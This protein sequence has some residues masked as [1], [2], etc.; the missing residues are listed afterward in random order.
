MKFR[1][2]HESKSRCVEV[3]MQVPPTSTYRSSTV[4]YK[5]H[6]SGTISMIKSVSLYKKNGLLNCQIRHI[7]QCK[8]S[9]NVI[10]YVHSHQ[11]SD[12]IK[13]LTQRA[14]SL[15][16]SS[17]GNTRNKVHKPYFAVG[18]KPSNKVEFHMRKLPSKYWKDW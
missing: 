12:I 6:C 7:P 5:W 17:D 4:F 10:F 3:F 16:V 14:Q 1:P 13:S 18:L 8:N 15:S 9:T 11:N 2:I